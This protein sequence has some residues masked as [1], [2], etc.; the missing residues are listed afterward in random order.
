[1]ET[2]CDGTS[3]NNVHFPINFLSQIL[4]Q[5]RTM[6]KFQTHYKENLHWAL[7]ILVLLHILYVYLTDIYK[8]L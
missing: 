5:I 6:L 7:K 4:Q 3:M 8:Y 1:M 2:I